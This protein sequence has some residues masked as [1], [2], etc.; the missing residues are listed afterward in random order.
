MCLIPKNLIFEFMKIT[1][2]LQ[3]PLVRNTLKL[4]SSSALLMLLPLIVTPILSR[5]YSPADYGDWGVFSSVFYVVNSFLFLSYENTIVKSNNEEEVPNLIGI[6]VIVSS[7]IILITLLTFTVGQLIGIDFFCN[8]PSVKLLI[9][10]LAAQAIHIIANNVANREKKYGLMSIANIIGGTTQASFRVAFG[11]YPIVAYGLIVG[12]VLA[13]VFTTL[14]IVICLLRTVQIEWKYLSFKRVVSLAKINKKFPQFDAPARFVEL[15]LANIALIIMTFFWNKSEIGSYSMVTQFVLLP[16]SI[17]GSSMGN[18][19]Y[20]ELCES[21]GKPDIIALTTQRAS[22]ITFMISFLPLLFFV[23][24]GDYLL[25]IVLGEKWSSAGSIAICLCIYSVPL[26][27]SEPL[28]PIF[29]SLDRQE[30]RFH[31]NLLNFVLS[32][33]SLFVT[34]AITHNLYIS[35]IVYSLFSGFVRYLMYF[36]ILKLANVKLQS[37]NKH[38][39]IISIICYVLI[40]VRLCFDFPN[41]I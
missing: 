11:V 21:A 1:K 8:F 17:V 33:G 28:L 10:L 23:F 13:Q 34:A 32:L 35:L 2:I 40:F 5:L 18:V 15:S 20:K 25:T 29:R 14:F 27:L 7:F 3:L 41:M 4:S 22:K 36:T 12:N 30:L 6:C 9:L 19:F 38:F 26:I 37:V 24:G 16:I 31:L 39:V